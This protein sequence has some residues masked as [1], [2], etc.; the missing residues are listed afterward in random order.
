MSHDLEGSAWIISFFQPT[1]IS[2]IHRRISAG[3]TRPGWHRPAQP[4]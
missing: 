4:I 3:P 1:G 2:G